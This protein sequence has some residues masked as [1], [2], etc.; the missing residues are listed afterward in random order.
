MSL[1]QS[2]SAARDNVFRY[3][4]DSDPITVRSLLLGLA[5]VHPQNIS[6]ASPIL[7]TNYLKSW[8]LN[9]PTIST[10]KNQNPR[11]LDL[12]SSAGE[13]NKYSQS[14]GT[15]CELFL[16]WLAQLFCEVRILIE[17]TIIQMSGQTQCPSHRQAH[18]FDRLNIEAMM[19]HQ[20]FIQK[21]P[22]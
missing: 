5:S 9:T 4:C 6:Q 2:S 3:C 15:R 21:K 12:R 20:M 19:C 18:W 10:A 16:V 22:M 1:E 17:L 8:Y 13:Q 7:G 11:L 14:R